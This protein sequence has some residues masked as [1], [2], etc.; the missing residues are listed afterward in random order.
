MLRGHEAGVDV[1]SFVLRPS[2]SIC[3][4]TQLNKTG[5]SKLGLVLCCSA[6]CCVE[7][8]RNQRLRFAVFSLAAASCFCS[9]VFRA[10]AFSLIHL[11]GSLLWLALLPFSGFLWTSV[12]RSGGRYRVTLL[13]FQVYILDFLFN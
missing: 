6:A 3:K 12:L 5:L 8:A 9:S 13:V 2:F 7:A 4:N 11:G 1:L 10:V